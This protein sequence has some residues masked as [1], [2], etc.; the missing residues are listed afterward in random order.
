[1][2][3]KFI[4]DKK[5]ILVL[6]GAGFIG[7]HLCEQ[8]VENYKVIC[9]DN[10]LSGVERNIDHLLADPNFKFIKHDMAKPLILENY[11]ELADFRIE[12]QG[13]QEIYNLASPTSPKYFEKNRIANILANSYVVKNG[14]DL[15][16]KYQAKYLHFS[17][18]VIYG[19]RID[20]NHRVSE[21]D[22]GITDVLSPRA[23][24]D[25]GKRF[26][27]TMISTYR[28]VYGIDAKIIRVFRV[29][30]PRM[31]L[32][33]GHMIPDFIESALEGVDVVIH[34]DAS[35]STSICYVDDVISAAM[36]MMDSEYTGP[37]NIGS[38]INLNLADV[39]KKIISMLESDSRISYA[40]PLLF[41]TPLALPNIAKA[42]QLLNWMPLTTLDNGL[43][44]TVDDLRASKGLK[45]V[46]Y[47]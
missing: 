43:R 6:G 31:P 38:D 18:S 46:N 24:Y 28:D 30:G 16:L 11:P 3:Q 17:S 47:Y 40:E 4:F 14:L 15:A 21:E 20:D 26:A 22:F 12:F 23:S 5:N 42:R 2:T 29:Y 7:S 19:G 36:K 33:E 13:V 37:I 44:K 41:M 8:L 45:S 34:G 1:M 32:A 10:F 9:V 35:F 25:E 27:E 39:A